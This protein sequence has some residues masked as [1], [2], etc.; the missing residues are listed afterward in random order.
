MTR[1]EAGGLRI[2]AALLRRP[3]V[4]RFLLGGVLVQ[5][6]YAMVNMALLI[7]A[8]DGYGSYSSAGL[9]AAVMSIAGAFFGPNVGRAIDRWGQKRVVGVIGAFWVFSIAVLGLV[10]VLRPPYWALVAVVVMLGISVPGGSLI[11]ARWREALREESSVMPSALSLT[12]VAEEFMW[13]LSTPIATALATLVSPIAALVFGIFTI[14]AG[15]HLLLGDSTFEPAPLGERVRARLRGA[16]GPRAELGSSGNEGE[17]AEAGSGDC[18]IE[19][20]FASAAHAEGS[21]IL[22]G[23]ADVRA[24]AEARAEA[25]GECAPGVAP[26]AQPSSSSAVERLWTPT[27]AVL[28]LVLIFYGAFQTTTGIAIVA[29]ARELDMQAWAGTVTACFSGGSM[30]GALVYGMRAWPGSLWARF[31]IGLAALAVSCS[32]LVL[33]GSMPAA[34]IVMLISGLFQAPTV[35]NINQ[36]FMRIVP[37]YRFTEGMALFGSMWVIGMSASNIV[38]GATIDRWGAFGGFATVVGFALGALVLALVSMP[39][40]KRALELRPEGGPS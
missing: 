10:L 1:G 30:V 8:R 12:S 3:H 20:A 31:Y 37:A 33:V 36:I 29:F 13:V 39:A 24:G 11:R 40:V 16:Q 25:V 9:A 35:V 19:G 18:G 15:L 28:L 21:M 5:F 34:A 26:T 38:A 14:L 32:L 17:R 2:Y 22:E 27:F 6:P 23:G 7:G 4:A